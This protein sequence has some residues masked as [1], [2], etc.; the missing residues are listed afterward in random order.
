MTYLTLL[1]L[2]SSAWDKKVCGIKMQYNLK[3]MLIVKYL[4]SAGCWWMSSSVDASQ[5]V[6]CAAAQ[7]PAQRQSVQMSEETHLDHAVSVLLHSNPQ[8]RTHVTYKPRRSCRW[9]SDWSQT[10]K[11][12]PRYT[13][14]LG[15]VCIP[16]QLHLPAGTSGTRKHT[17]SSPESSRSSHLSAVH[18]DRSK[19]SC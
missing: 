1:I 12:I 16:H 2:Y 15:D 9:R 8:E 5:D 17:L 4:T 6:P 14:K 11:D 18:C 7:V 13:I 19:S 3:L 10:L